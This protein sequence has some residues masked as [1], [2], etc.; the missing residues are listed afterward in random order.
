[1]VL[2]SL[3]SHSMSDNLGRR[4]GEKKIFFLEIIIWLIARSAQHSAYIELHRLSD[5]FDV[6]LKDEKSDLNSLHCQ[7]SDRLENG[8]PQFHTLN[9]VRM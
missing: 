6:L 7:I 2:A 3:K 5:I 9:T 1:M 8:H 4:R